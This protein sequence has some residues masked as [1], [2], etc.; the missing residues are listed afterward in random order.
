MRFERAGR[1]YEFGRSQWELSCRLPVASGDVFGFFSEAGESGASVTVFASA[2]N[3]S[4]GGT[5]I[6]LFNRACSASDASFALGPPPTA[7]DQSPITRT[8][9]ITIT[10]SRLPKKLCDEGLFF[11]ELPNSGVDLVAAEVIQ[12]HVLH[13]FAAVITGGPDRERADDPLLHSV[14]AI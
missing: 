10:I 5:L 8:S 4:C 14:A 11:Q 12:T 9:T 2:P 3:V 6:S 7:P 13:H 1:Y